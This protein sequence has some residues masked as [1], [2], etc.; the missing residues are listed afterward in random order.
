LKNPPSI[1]FCKS[2][3][4][5]AIAFTA[6][7]SGP[8]V[9][10]V[11]LQYTDNDLASPGP[12]SQHWMD[13]LTA[14]H[15]VIR[16]DMRGCGLSERR[17]E[18]MCLDA[19]VEDIEA[20]VNAAG[21]TRFA[22][23][24]VCTGS[25]AAIEYAA[26]HTTQ[27]TRLMIYGGA[28]RGRLQRELTAAQ[29]DDAMAALQVYES[30]LDGRSEFAVSFRRIFT[31]Q[32]FPDASAG[33]LEAHD[34]IVSQRMNGAIAAQS[35][36]AFYDLDLS[37][38]AKR[39]DTPCLVL[40]ARH[41]ILYP[42]EEGQRLAALIPGSRFVPVESHN[43]IPLAE[44]PAWP[45]VR[46]T[47]LEFL[48]GNEG[49]AGPAQTFRLTVRQADVL[50]QVAQGQTDKQIARTLSLS[51]RTVEM[52]VGAALKAMGSKTRAEAAHRAAQYGLF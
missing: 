31:A 11:T 34:R 25:Y 30:G 3:D 6:T 4:G 20:V 37:E 8:P 17:P 42:M 5:T 14:R 27:L 39:I 49:A 21:L 45:R 15:T 47:V 2:A 48:A 1:R 41:D 23:M 13:A 18:R 38:S 35:V 28:V 32:F 43:N 7:G 46:G 10:W 24:A 36:R 50:R 9:V 12:A 40:H 16:L 26:R 29:R 51:P 52:H 22:M 33:Q 44:E 19:W